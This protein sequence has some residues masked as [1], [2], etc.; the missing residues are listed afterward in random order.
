MR[1]IIFKVSD[2]IKNSIVLDFLKGLFHE[3]F[4]KYYDVRHCKGIT[5]IYS[6]VIEA[7]RQID[8]FEPRPIQGA[9]TR[10]GQSF[11][12]IEQAAKNCIKD[13]ILK[14]D[15]NFL[16][17]LF[18]RIPG[19]EVIKNLRQ[20]FIKA[21]EITKSIIGIYDSYQSQD[22]RSMGI[23]V[24]KI[25]NVFLKNENST[26]IEHR[27][28]THFMNGFSYG[29]SPSLYLDMEECTEDVGIDVYQQ[30]E[31]DIYD[32]DFS[33]TAKSI[34]DFQDIAM[35]FT[36]I[37]EDCETEVEVKNFINKLSTLLNSE[38]FVEDAA[39]TINDPVVFATLLEELNEDLI[40]GNFYRVGAEVGEFLK[41]VLDAQE[42][43]LERT[44]I[45]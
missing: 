40:D 32:L 38:T 19:F 11:Y 17:D 2:E 45:K 6:Y 16:Y 33:D 7:A 34:K 14:K 26:Q 1:F 21:K 27:A 23:Y 28:G 8:L 31:A 42:L 37:I 12:E 18:S 22:W 44:F 4:G 43:S 35:K 9:I 3:L 15:S 25:G 20:V 5:N 24:G 41:N 10:F 36:S 30:V 39:K 13:E 29:V